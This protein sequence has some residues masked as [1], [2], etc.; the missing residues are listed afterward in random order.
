[1]IALLEEQYEEI[2]QLKNM[3][4]KLVEANLDEKETIDQSFLIGSV[5]IVIPAPLDGFV[6]IGEINRDIM[7]V[8]V[9]DTNKL[10]CGFVMPD[11]LARMNEMDEDLVLDRYG[12]VQ[13]YRETADQEMSEQDFEKIALMFDELMKGE[14]G[15]IL[16]KASNDLNQRLEDAGIDA[17]ASIKKPVNLGKLFTIK[18]A[19]GYGFIMPY[20]LKMDGDDE[21]LT[22][23]AGIS[24]LRVKNRFMFL[25]LFDTYENAES[26]K[27]IDSTS[28]SWC[29]AILK[30]N[31]Q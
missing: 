4:E 18:D 16:D 9:P 13:I 14:F 3:V 21:S 27:W 22:M 8:F 11:D 19:S 31:N 24:I 15:S 12:L 26:I 20:D 7:E 1:M 25:Y 6:E 30:A 17:Q 23:A 28:E 29:K 5:K 10:V 2:K